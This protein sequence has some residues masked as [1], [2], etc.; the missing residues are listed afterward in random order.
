MG[1]FWDKYVY[2][3]YFAQILPLYILIFILGSFG[4]NSGTEIGTFTK[5][6]K[7]PNLQRAYGAGNVKP[8]KGEESG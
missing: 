7:L 6:K 3:I 4:S 2:T 5:T 8:C 1:I